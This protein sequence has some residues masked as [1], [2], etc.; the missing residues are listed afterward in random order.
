MIYDPK[1][2]RGDIIASIKAR[3]TN[4]EGLCKRFDHG[5]NSLLQIAV[6]GTVNQLC[7]ERLLRETSK[8]YLHCTDDGL[9]Y[10]TNL[11]YYE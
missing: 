5:T 11:G 10:I 4:F 1:T 6:M 3:S 8:G 7:R 2:V 9:E